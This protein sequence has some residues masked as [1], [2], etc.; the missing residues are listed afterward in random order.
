MDIF[1][2]AE[3]KHPMWFRLRKRLVRLICVLL[4]SKTIRHR[5]RNYFSP[6]I[7]NINI[8]GQ[9]NTIIVVKDGHEYYDLDGLL[10]AGLSN[11]IIRGNNNTL[12]LFLPLN[13]GE[14]GVF[15]IELN[16]N[17][18]S[19][20]IH[21]STYLGLRL[22]CGDNANKLKIGKNTAMRNVE[23]KLCDACEVSIGEDCMFSCEITMYCGDGHTVLDADTNQIINRPQYPFV[24]GD[25]CWIGQSVKMTKHAS[26][27]SNSIVG[28]GAVVT[29]RFTENNVVIAGNPAQ[30]VKHGINWHQDNIMTFSQT[31]QKDTNI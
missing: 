14:H 12:K 17:D 22:Y 6:N 21:Q 26:V 25:H 19:V 10:L 23:L 31:M 5:I 16:G 27:A 2:P 8:S 3:A 7:R 30:I 15:S 11:I 18:N 9:H 24:I 4:P 20:E 1:I 13:P 29:K 28:I